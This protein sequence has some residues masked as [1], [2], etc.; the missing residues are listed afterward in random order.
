MREKIRQQDTWSRGWRDGDNTP[1]VLIEVLIF[2]NS[3]RDFASALELRSL[4]MC[5][6]A[7][8]PG[9]GLL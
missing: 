4:S 7:C 6:L 8:L 5:V 9:A 1:I 2:G 3:R